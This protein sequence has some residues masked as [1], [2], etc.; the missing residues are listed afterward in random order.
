LPRSRPLATEY[1][2]ATACSNCITNQVTIRDGDQGPP[3]GLIEHTHWRAVR[4]RS[5]QRG[6][7]FTKLLGLR[8]SNPRVPGDAPQLAQ[9]LRNFI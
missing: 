8:V 1:I 5:P 3:P 6:K 4:H 7:A 2:F 9:G